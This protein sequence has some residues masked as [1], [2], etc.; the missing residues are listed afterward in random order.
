LIQVHV[1][2]ILLAYLILM[3]ENVNPKIIGY[4]I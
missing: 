1:V 3:S 2:D 4:I